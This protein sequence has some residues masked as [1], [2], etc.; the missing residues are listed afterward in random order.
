MNPF[1]VVIRAA[2]PFV[3]RRSISPKCSYAIKFAS[4]VHLQ[5]QMNAQLT[6]DSQLTFSSV[7]SQLVPEHFNSVVEKSA[8]RLMIHS[9]NYR[10]EAYSEPVGHPRFILCIS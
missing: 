2:P 6:A 1:K 4:L 10:S 7:Q 9:V 3:F 5:L 8:F